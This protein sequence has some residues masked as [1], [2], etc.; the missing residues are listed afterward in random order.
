MA[1]FKFDYAIFSDGSCRMTHGAY[2]AIVLKSNKILHT[3]KGIAY[4]TTNNRMELMGAIE[5]LKKIPEGKSVILYTDSQYVITCIYSVRKWHK[6]D[7]SS[8]NGKIANSD[9]LEQLLPLVSLVKITPK[10]V[11]GHSGN[12]YN[13][14]CD[15][16]AADLTDKMVRGKPIELQGET[17]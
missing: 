14:M 6:S 10:W 9:V 12:T 17:P 1:K 15:Q 16:I 2:A 8:V 5:G 4:K 3:V 13:E 11:K 7:W